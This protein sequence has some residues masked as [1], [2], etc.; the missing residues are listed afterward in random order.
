MKGRVYI[1]V[2]NREWAE[3][4]EN[5]YIRSVEAFKDWVWNVLSRSFESFRFEIMWVSIGEH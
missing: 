1:H 2:G 5:P 4:M 3:E